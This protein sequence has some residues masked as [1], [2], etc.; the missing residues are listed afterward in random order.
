MSILSGESNGYYTIPFNNIQ[1]NK[2]EI[3]AFSCW[4]GASFTG[5]V[6]NAVCIASVISSVIND[7]S[8]EPDTTIFR[9]DTN[10]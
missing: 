3:S 6:S 8:E 4:G 7:V 2:I 9:V 1:C 10:V 5:A